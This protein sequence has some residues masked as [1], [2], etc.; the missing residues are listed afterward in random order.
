MAFD[1]SGRFTK[2]PSVAGATVRSVTLQPTTAMMTHPSVLRARILQLLLNGEDWT[3]GKISRGLSREAV[4]GAVIVTSVTL[5]VP[6]LVKEWDQALDRTLDGLESTGLLTCPRRGVYRITATGRRLAKAHPNSIGDDLLPMVITV[7]GGILNVP[8]QISGK[9]IITRPARGPGRKSKDVFK[10]DPG[11]LGGLGD[12]GGDMGPAGGGRGLGSL[13]T[14]G[15]GGGGLGYGRMGP[16]PK[17]YAGPE[18]FSPKK[19]KAAPPPEAG[20][21]TQIPWQQPPKP[22][23][24]PQQNAPPYMPGEAVPPIPGAPMERADGGVDYTVWYGTNRRPEPK[25]DGGLAYSGERD[26]R[27]HYGTCR[28][29][30]PKWHEFGSTGTGGVKG[31]FNRVIRRR[32]DRLHVVDVREL[33]PAL[34]WRSLRSSLA[35]VEEKL[36][37]ALVYIHGYNVPFESAA[38]RAAQMGVDLKVPGATAFYSWPSTGTEIGYPV[39]EAAV[40]GAEKHLTEFLTRFAAQAGAARVDVIAHSMGNRGLLRSIIAAAGENPRLRFGQIILAAPDVDADTFRNLA[41]VYPRVSQRTTLYVSDKDKAL[42]LSK[43]GHGYDRAGYKPPTMVLPDID[44]I[45]VSQ[46]D[47]DFLGHSYYG[48]AEGVLYDMHE[49]IWTGRPPAQRARIDRAMEAGNI[50]WK[51]RA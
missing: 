21:S 35:L 43:F 9:A 23:P 22:K 13:G 50:F 45:E 51:V 47:V 33:A 28:V 17:I 18:K 8:G 48:E 3:K 41:S 6:G 36:R 24:Q 16:K 49:L 4:K 10:L 44:T 31:W 30:V 14:A 25:P 29:V 7:E 15:K 40:E 5:K 46:L 38:I 2:L 34:F 42:W 12:F 39:D 11:S 37:I 1:G 20:G 27:L 19:L 26:D 32:D